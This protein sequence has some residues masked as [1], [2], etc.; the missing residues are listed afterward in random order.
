MKVLLSLAVAGL[1]RGGIAGL[2][3]RPVGDVSAARHAGERRAAHLRGRLRLVRARRSRGQPSTGRRA[4]HSRPWRFRRLA[5]ARR[6]RPAPERTGRPRT[7]PAAADS[8]I[9]GMTTCG[10]T[11]PGT[12]AP[13][14]EDRVRRRWS[15]PMASPAWAARPASRSAIST[16]RPTPA[17]ARRASINTTTRSSATPISTLGP[18]TAS[19]PMSAAASG[20]T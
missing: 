18:T 5:S 16:I 11:R 13:A 9:G 4:F 8:A 15:A 14:Q 6:S 12:T 10:S 20:S 2:R 7:S 17:T 19:R 3:R 1:D